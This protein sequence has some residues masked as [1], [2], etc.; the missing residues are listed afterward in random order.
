MVGV[1]RSVSA[2]SFIARSKAAVS[3]S[4]AGDMSSGLLKSKRCW[5]TGGETERKRQQGQ[6]SNAWLNPP[7]QS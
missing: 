7:E 5:A 3:P 6:Q 4:M 2:I 1:G